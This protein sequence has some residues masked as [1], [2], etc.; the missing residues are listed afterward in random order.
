MEVKVALLHYDR[1]DVIVNSTSRHRID[2]PGRRHWALQVSE[3]II[4]NA[5]TD[6]GNRARNWPYSR[7]FGQVTLN[8]LQL[9]NPNSE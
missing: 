7:Q 6:N 1:Q 3:C 9:A 2:P 4:A 5:L 8:L